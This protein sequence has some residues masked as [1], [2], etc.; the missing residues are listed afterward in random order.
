MVYTLKLRDKET[1]ILERIRVFAKD[2]ASAKL[3]AVRVAQVKRQLRSVK[4]VF[5]TPQNPASGN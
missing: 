2:E 4:K 3:E 5:F 1:G